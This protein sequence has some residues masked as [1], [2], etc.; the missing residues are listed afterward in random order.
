MHSRNTKHIPKLYSPFLE[1]KIGTFLEDLATLEEARKVYER[2]G[3]QF[4]IAPPARI[5]IDDY[6]MDGNTALI[7][8]VIYGCFNALTTLLKAKANPNMPALDGETP[9]AIAAEKGNKYIIKCLL[10]AKAQPD[11]AEAKKATPLQVAVV[12]SN[13]SIVQ[14]LLEAHA[15]PNLVGKYGHTPLMEATI[16]NKP[17]IARA[18]L[19]AK[20][21]LEIRTH[22]KTQTQPITDRSAL[23]LAIMWSIPE[24]ATMLLMEGAMITD[25][26]QM[27]LYLKK[28][29]QRGLDAQIGFQHLNQQLKVCTEIENKNASNTHLFL[30]H[31][32]TSAYHLKLIYLYNIYLQ[33]MTEWLEEFNKKE[34]LLPTDLLKIVAS[35]D[36]PLERCRFFAYSEIDPVVEAAAVLDRSEKTSLR[37]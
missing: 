28:L 3:P 24:M 33:Q 13:L 29:D 10:A 34:S 27:D 31:E 11:Y 21:Q 36:T 9:L 22:Y 2:L 4:G 17:P 25:F 1:E 18:L 12:C 15:S 30:I 8:S 6:D 16:L 37:S 32:I 35:Y 5:D 20:A 23:D 19:D 26:L 7:I 14:I